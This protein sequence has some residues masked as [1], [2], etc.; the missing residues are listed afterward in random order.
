[1]GVH[2]VMLG[3]HP[4]ALPLLGHPVIRGPPERKPLLFVLRQLLPLVVVRDPQVAP[5]VEGPARL[6][7]LALFDLLDGD[8]DQIVAGTFLLPGVSPSDR[9]D[10]D[11]RGP[12]TLFGSALGQRLCG[13]AEYGEQSGGGDPT[14][15]HSYLRR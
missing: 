5:D 15:S 11:V 7:A 8:L 4:N 1:V 6:E 10:N 2:R 12:A 13:Q 9:A 3:M 14:T